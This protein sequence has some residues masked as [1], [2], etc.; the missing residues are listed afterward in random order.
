MIAI[1]VIMKNVSGLL[2]A[3]N[4]VAKFVNRR[5]GPYIRKEGGKMQESPACARGDH[6]DCDGSFKAGG[7]KLSCLCLQCNHGRP[8]PTVSNHDLTVPK[9]WVAPPGRPGI[10]QPGW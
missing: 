3:G 8:K 2:R 9:D 7:Y 10:R 4:A 1:R 5:L 6:S